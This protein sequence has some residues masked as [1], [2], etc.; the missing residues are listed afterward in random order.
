[1]DNSQTKDSTACSQD[2]EQLFREC[3]RRGKEETFC[4]I[5]RVPCDSDCYEA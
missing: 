1:M 5:Q 3:L 2:C 4:R